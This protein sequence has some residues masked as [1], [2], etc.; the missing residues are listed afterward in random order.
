MQDHG[1]MIN[2]YIRSLLYDMKIPEEMPEGF[3]KIEGMIEIDLTLRELRRS[4]RA[5]GIGALS[6]KIQ[7]TGYVFGIIKDLQSALRNLTW[8][9]KAISS[10][11]FSQRVDFLGE[12]SESFNDMVK[13]LEKAILE[14]EEGRDLFEM[15][16]ETIPDATIIISLEEGK[17]LDCNRAS[18]IMTGCS[19][20]KLQGQSIKEIGLFRDKKQEKIFFDAVQKNSKGD[21]LLVELTVGE[22]S[23][24]YGLFSWDTILIEREKHTLCVIKDIS[25]RKR[26]EEEIRRLSET[27]GLTQINNRLKLDS[28]LKLEMERLSRSDSVCSVIILD[29]DFF[30]KVNDTYGHLVGDEVLK[31][32][33][34]IIRKG[35]RKIDTVGRWGGEEFMVIMPLTEASKGMVLAEKLRNKISQH[36]FTGV[37]N[38]TASFGIAESRG[39]LNAVEL[40]AKADAAMYQAKDAG[41]NQVC[42][43]PKSSN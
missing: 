21:N 5:I 4:I 22:D 37:E 3:R 42:K 30:K 40:V 2:E 13:K 24:I 15:F 14:V 27:D 31:D 8:Q 28:V 25:D 36:V 16:F 12:F 6:E 1:L 23:L 19:K 18:E 10:G 43:S 41:R 9:T 39:D 26:M 34:D 17:I 33:A 32:V 38:L 7:G 29:I 35:V 11:D 20:N